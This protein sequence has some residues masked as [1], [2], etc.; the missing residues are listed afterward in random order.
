MTD[1][2]TSGSRG[3]PRGWHSVTPRI[4]AHDSERLI[5]FLRRVFGATGNYH[6]DRPAEMK[7]GDSILMVTEAGVREP[8]TAFL[9]VYVDDADETY[10]E[11]LRAGADSLEEPFNQAYGDRRG[12]RDVARRDL[13]REGD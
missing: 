8:M 9:Y 3:T 13:S 5:E 7:I 4:V 12:A 6:P 10:R 11:A 2:M 1:E